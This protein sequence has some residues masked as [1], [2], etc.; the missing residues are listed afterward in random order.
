MR[1]LKAL[2]NDALLCLSTRT[3]TSGML[4]I[5]VR[6]DNEQSY[7]SLRIAAYGSEMPRK[8]PTDQ[9]APG[10]ARPLKST[11]WADATRHDILPTPAR[12]SRGRPQ[13]MISH[14]AVF[15]N[16]FSSPRGR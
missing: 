3:A 14:D 6:I 11:I 2:A 15:Q 8:N 1:R 7:V 12:P 4:L 13:V 9:D 10:L 5:Y 16:A